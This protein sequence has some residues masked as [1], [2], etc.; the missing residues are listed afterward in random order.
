MPTTSTSSRTAPTTP[1][2]S[3]GTGG[4][5]SRRCGFPCRRIRTW[6][7]PEDRPVTSA[8]SLLQAILE[9]PDDDAPRLVYADWLEEHGTSEAEKAWAEFIR[10][11][12]AAD[13]RE[14]D[15]DFEGHK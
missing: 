10:L 15:P 14:E 9:S 6:T 3:A 11:Q 8:E 7:G 2:S 4:R 12:V 1:T 5:A 13:G